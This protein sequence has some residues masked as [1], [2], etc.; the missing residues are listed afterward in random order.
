MS[1]TQVSAPATPF[2]PKD[3]RIKAQRDPIKDTP[4]SFSPPATSSTVTDSSRTTKQSFFDAIWSSVIWTSLDRGTSLFKHIYIASMLGLSAELD[5]FYMAVGLISLFVFSWSRIADI[6]A[7]P[8]LVELIGAYD[9]DAARK[10]TGDLFTLS[11]VFSV[12]L[13]LALIWAWPLCIQLAWGFEPLRKTKLEESIVWALPLVFLYIP[14]RMLYSFSKARRAFYIT[15]RNEFFISLVMLGC[16][17]LYP[18]TEGVLMWSYSLGVAFAFILTLTTL[19]KQVNYLGSPWSRD[20]KALLP[21]IPALL[22]LYGAQY[23]YSMVNRQFVSN[24]PQGAV[25]AVAY[26]WTL[27]TLPPSLLG[28]GGAFVTIYAEN[29]DNPEE[30]ISK[31][32]NLISATLFFGVFMTLFIFGFSEDFIGL[33]LERGH[34]TR[35]NTLMV[36]NCTAYFAFSI[37]PILLIAPIGQIFQVERKLRLIVRR[38]LFGLV[39]NVIFSYLF[40]FMLGWGMEGVALATSIS[41]WGMLVASVSSIN[42]LGLTIDI[43]RHVRWLLYL[44]STGGVA[45][46]LSLQLKAMSPSYLR[47]IPEAVV[48]SAL[49]MLALMVSKNQDGEFAKSLLL[50]SLRK[51]RLQKA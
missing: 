27:T 20:I 39:L 45:L 46:F 21:L 24:L 1:P 31:V 18:R 10:Y 6:I 35:E 41:Q 51:L 22:V 9:T 26:G 38:V 17:T 34:F 8:R 12:T 42:K 28:L 11:V 29:K 25:S 7:V 16:V 44:T 5:V 3:T 33:I 32:N 30:K 2:R 36:A 13:G 23:L 15:Y 37:I 19:G 14:L 40:M 47:L 49:A 50:R 48:F 4:R 43:W